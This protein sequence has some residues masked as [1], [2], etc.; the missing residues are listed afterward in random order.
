MGVF[1]RLL[2]RSSGTPRKKSADV[3]PAAD[4]GAAEG[5][6]EQEQNRAAA[7]GPGDEAEDIGIPKQ[8]SAEEAADSEAADSHK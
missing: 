6:T 3:A 2:R 8:Q 4:A 1:A 7:V 5:Q